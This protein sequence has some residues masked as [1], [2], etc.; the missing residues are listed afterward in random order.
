MWK[1]GYDSLNQFHVFGPREQ[2]LKNIGGGG[3]KCS[4]RPKTQRKH[5][6]DKQNIFFYS[7]RFEMISLNIVN[8]L[9]PSCLWEEPSCISPDVSV[10]ANYVWRKGQVWGVL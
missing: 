5:E 1:W 8:K 3:G 7:F 6:I 4:L 10:G 2:F 9:A